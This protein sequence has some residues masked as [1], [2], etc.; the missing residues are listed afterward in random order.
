MIISGDCMPLPEIVFG[1]FKDY[2]GLLF[3]HS[4]VVIILT[5]RRLWQLFRRKKRRLCVSYLFPEFQQFF[6]SR[7]A[8][9]KKKMN[10]NPPFNFFADFQLHCEV[11]SLKDCDC[12]DFSKSF[13]F[14]FMKL[15]IEKKKHSPSTLTTTLL[16]LLHQC[17][18]RPSSSTHS[19]IGSTFGS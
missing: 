8:W 17:T 4:A 13:S 1:C 19:E 7:S 18:F 14:F 15:Q 6:F 2:K 9:F 5:L 10:K 11:S 16:L 12:L 3:C